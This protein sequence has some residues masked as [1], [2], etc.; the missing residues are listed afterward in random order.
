VPLWLLFFSKK[1]NDVEEIEIVIK[2]EGA[3]YSNHFIG[4]LKDYYLYL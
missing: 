3:N 4:F 2:A 1:E